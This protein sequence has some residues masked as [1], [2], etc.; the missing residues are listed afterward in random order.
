MKIAI[1]GSGISG[2]TAAWLLHQSHEITVFE[3]NDY[4]GGHTHTI[5]VNVD[6]EQLAIDT[7]FIVYND[8]TY[9]NFI[10]ML[11]R[12]GVSSL[13]TE[14][15]FSVRCER[16]RLEY[17]GSNLN[18]LFAQRSNL[19]K[20]RFHRMLQDILRF[21]REALELLEADHDSLTVDEY[22]TQRGYSRQ[23][24]DHYLIPMGAA[25]WSCP[26]ETFGKFPVRFIVEFYRNHGLLSIKNRPQWRVI[27]GGSQR[28]IEKLIAP[29]RDRIRL[30]SPVESIAREEGAVTIHAEGS[31]DESFD[32]V[33]L[34][35]HSDQALSILGSAAT[36]TERNVLNEFP[37]QKNSAVLHWDDSVL[38]QRRRAWASWNYHIDGPTSQTD[39]Q[40]A[41]PSGQSA[42]V[43]YNMNILQRLKA[44]KTYCVTL[45]R[46]AA[47]DPAKIIGRYEYHHPVYTTERRAAQ[48]K[49]PDLINHNR[50]SFCGAYWG[51]GFHEDGV[52]SA[53]AVCRQL[54]VE[55]PWQP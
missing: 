7:G 21:N 52:N 25:I 3:A 45:N 1:I 22:V 34:A 10:Q 53:L 49:H 31:D 43:T 14:M 48:R 39:Q 42:T 35:C 12:L 11:E 36:T 24:S 15:S 50:T 37:Y 33:I 26:P 4:I 44:Q 20:P 40:S 17:N 16:S 29:V 46:D 5:D 19:L 38:P 6:G 27:S 9:P 47:I 54:G 2:L 41:E 8:W 32:H 18:G 51:N 30:N 13:A 28:Y 55:P 23:F